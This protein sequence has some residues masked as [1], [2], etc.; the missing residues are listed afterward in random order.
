VIVRAPVA[1]V[2][3]PKFVELMFVFGLPQT[4]RFSAL[5]ASARISNVR[6]S[7]MAIVLASDKSRPRRDGPVTPG[8]FAERLSVDRQKLS[9][10][11]ESYNAIRV[12]NDDGSYPALTKSVANYLPGAV[13]PAGYGSGIG[14][15]TLN[16][17]GAFLMRDVHYGPSPVEAEDL[18][19]FNVYFTDKAPARPTQEMQL[20]TLGI[21]EIVPPFIIPP[22][23]VKTM[24]PHR[25]ASTQRRVANCSPAETTKGSARIA[26]TNL[27]DD[28]KSKRIPDWLVQ[29][30]VCL[31]L[32]EQWGSLTCGHTRAYSSFSATVPA[33]T[34]L[35]AAG[36]P[37]QG[38]NHRW[39][40]L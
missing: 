2:M 21:S 26:Q 12:L 1:V 22:K 33:P 16:R 35:S 8:T 31:I 39:P 34:Y 23:E 17:R 14:G 19:F 11:E 6:D 10:L 24:T 20:G 9:T 25:D 3:R 28:H 36:V 30:Y 40:L 29:I 13:S 32:S 38:R 4:G 18:S 5:T 7:P 37:N 15:W 27:I